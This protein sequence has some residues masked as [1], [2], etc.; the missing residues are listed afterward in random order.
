MFLKLVA[1]ISVFNL[2]IFT[3]DNTVIF[4]LNKNENLKD[5]NISVL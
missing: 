2:K 5:L 4:S 3:K 1:V